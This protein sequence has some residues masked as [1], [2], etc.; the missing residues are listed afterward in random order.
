MVFEDVWPQFDGRT[1]V[2]THLCDC[3]SV[4]HFNRTRLNFNSIL[5]QHCQSL[6]DR[7]WREQKGQTKMWKTLKWHFT[8][9]LCS[10]YQ[11]LTLRCLEMKFI[12]FP[13]ST[14]NIFFQTM[15]V[16]HFSCFCWQPEYSAETPLSAW[17][18]FIG[19]QVWDD[20]IVFRIKDKR[21]KMAGAEK[22]GTTGRINWIFSIADFLKIIIIIHAGK[23]WRPSSIILTDCNSHPCPVGGRCVKLIA[24]D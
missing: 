5:H 15:W 7:E 9:K 13:S 14:I 19:L 22:G 8:A 2:I 21:T 23:F 12:F 20:F 11:L 17:I 24:T 6:R 18:N 4:K 3:V 16:P 1:G 10:V